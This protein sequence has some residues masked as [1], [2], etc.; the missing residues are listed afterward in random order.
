MR[1]ALFLAADVAPEAQPRRLHR[2]HRQKRAGR[3]DRRRYERLQPSVR[4]ASAFPVNHAVQRRDAMGRCRRP[5]TSVVPV[6]AACWSGT[7]GKT[8]RK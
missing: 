3:A 6:A 2:A 7:G 8:C 1:Q 4:R 5:E